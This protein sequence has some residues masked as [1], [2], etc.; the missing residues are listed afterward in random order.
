MV[1]V[2]SD[3]QLLGLV[4]IITIAYHDELYIHYFITDSPIYLSYA[5][6]SSSPNVH[7]R[8]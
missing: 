7:P 3:V 6:S 4:H 5:L 2:A 1:L 8:T